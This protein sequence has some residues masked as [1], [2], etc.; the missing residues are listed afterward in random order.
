M[1][2]ARR[3]KQRQRKAAKTVPGLVEVIVRPGAAAIGRPAL[4]RLQVHAYGEFHRFDFATGDQLEAAVKHL[5]A[6]LKAA[7]VRKGSE[8]DTNLLPEGRYQGG[9]EYTL[10]I[11]ALKSDVPPIN[12]LKLVL[13]GLLRA[14][15][16]RCTRITET[17]P[18]VPSLASQMA[19]DA[20][21]DHETAQES[22]E[23]SRPLP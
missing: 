22:E 6:A 17:T 18:G 19:Q 8:Q 12:R 13:K 5:A 9:E 10:T 11:R 3:E 14:Y 20:T 1:S 2:R 15:E 7:G 4:Y 23:F 16:F 21:G